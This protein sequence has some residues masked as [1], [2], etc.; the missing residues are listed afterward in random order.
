MCPAGA[1]AASWSLTQ[2]VVGLN[3]FPVVVTEFSKFSEKIEEK[4]KYCHRGTS[5]WRQSLSSFNSSQDHITGIVSRK[6]FFLAVL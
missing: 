3:P 2:E 1:I 6:R 4:L 5:H